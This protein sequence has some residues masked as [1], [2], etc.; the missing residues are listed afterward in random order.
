LNVERR[1][2]NEGIEDG[3]YSRAEYCEG[4][5]EGGAENLIG[6][7]FRVCEAARAMIAV[8]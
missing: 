4:G 8:R 2:K 1:D 7:A 3:R 5:F 6:I